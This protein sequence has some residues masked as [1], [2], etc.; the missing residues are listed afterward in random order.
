VW[1][2]KHI[3][4]AFNTKYFEINQL[5]K[6][7]IMS[8]REKGLAKAVDEVLPNA[9]HSYCCQHI[10][11]NIQSRYRITCWKLFWAAVYTRTKAEFNTAINAICKE[12]RPAAAYLRLIPVET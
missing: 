12:S 3:R 2:L 1:F 6:L 11:A 8:D 10:A 4:E 5:E 9:K 7:V